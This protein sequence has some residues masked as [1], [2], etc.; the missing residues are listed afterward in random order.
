MGSS[1]TS[2]SHFTKFELTVVSVTDLLGTLSPVIIGSQAAG[3][4][5]FSISWNT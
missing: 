4:V 5:G 2:E 1:N 3:N